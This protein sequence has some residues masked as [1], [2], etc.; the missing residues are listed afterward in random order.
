MRLRALAALAIVFTIAPGVPASADTPSAPPPAVAQDP[1][2]PVTA[3]APGEPPAPV[4][5]TPAPTESPAPKLEP[6][7]AADGDG[8]RVIVEVTTP[9][10]AVPVAGE[11][12]ELPGAEV[13]LQPPDT[14]FI[15]VD[16]TGESLA[17]LAADPRVVSVRRDRTYS[18]V[19][20]ASGLTLI[21]ADRAQAEGTTGEGKM[22]AV[23]D[24]GID[25]DHPAL[26]GKV[27]EEACFSATDDGAKSL[28]PG[29]GE[30]QTGPGSADAETPAC[31]NGSVN[32]C[33]HGT[34]V[35]GIAH[36]V[37]PGAEIAAVQVFSRID[38]CDEGGACLS[39]YESTILLALD[40]VARLKDTHPGLVAV[41]M[42]L[43]GG[44]YDGACDGEAEVGPMKE[45]IEALRAKG[46]VTV[47]AA[48]NEGF[49]GAG[50]P[51]CVSS[52]VTV[53]ATDDGDRIPE[54]SNRGSVLDLFAPGVEID[55]SVPGGATA[56]Y[57]GTSMST[58]HVTGALAAMAQKSPGDAPDALV[59]KLTAAGR[60][61]VYDGVTT[62][63]LD[64]YGALTGRAPS[65]PATQQPGLD[66][67]APDPN[68]DPDPS[69]GPSPEPDPADTPAPADPTPIPL[70]TVTV[71]VTVTATPTAPAV[72][73]RGTAKKTLT[74]AQWA[75]EM[76][77]GKGQLTDGTL[78]CYL[79][80]VAK[81]SK[82]FPE[83]TRAA[84]PGTAY[85][86]LRPAAKTKLTGKIKLESELLAAW[87]NWAHGGV[88]FTA[89]INEST[90]VRQAL[91]AA[92]QQR[93]KSAYSS[94]YL[95]MLKKHVNS[96]RI[97]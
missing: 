42:S 47:A 56:V 66:D 43:G 77:R 65:P 53:G 45:K 96:R 89:K 69:S 31:V 6:G 59:G 85:R 50:A 61:V 35:A 92:E 48:G 83:L 94:K 18:P 15:V 80:L 84:T 78:G 90:T 93:L 73:T 24:T 11:A 86:V 8:A 76:T 88:N 58:P 9:A 95:T 14:S 20:L 32:L 75:T 70:P 71:T 63:R 38:D 81:A 74:A 49:A 39:A 3:P 37:A 30:T 33:D 2:A 64:L 19:S 79:R 87:L 25:R 4:T 57:S 28:C 40:H 10:E 82:V 52:A 21:G 12:R 62:P 22:I 91:T 34:H 55:S 7:L 29:G 54:W 16:G 5:T 72:C 26:N 51:G 1:P 67:P 23:I 36:A 68:P 27:V 60:P 17:A 46:V 97:A 41:N 44:L 13:V